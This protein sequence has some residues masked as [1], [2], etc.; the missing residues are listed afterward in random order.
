MEVIKVT[1]GQPDVP[2]EVPLMAWD[3]LQPASEIFRA[4][5]V[6]HVGTPGKGPELMI[7]L[8]TDLTK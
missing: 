2:D 8:T 3:L 7:Q 5:S 1:E 4:K 6:K